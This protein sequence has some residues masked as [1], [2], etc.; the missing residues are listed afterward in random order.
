MILA[1]DSAFRSTARNALACIALALVLG[2]SGCARLREFR[3][4]K[5]NAFGTDTAWSDT[6]PSGFERAAA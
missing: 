6:S 2:N 4:G 5:P 3:Q 1:T